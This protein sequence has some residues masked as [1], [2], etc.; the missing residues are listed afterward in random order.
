MNLSTI[1]KWFVEVN[2]EKRDFISLAEVIDLLKNIEN[3]ASCRVWIGKD[4]GPRPWWHRLLGTQKRFV[5]SLFA[6]E[7]HN[8]IA[9][10]IFHDKNWSEHRAIDEGNPV[11][12]KEQDRLKVAQGEKNA[13]SNEECINKQRALKAVYEYLQKNKR[14]DWLVYNFVE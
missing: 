3:L 1:D 7:W 12:A 13:P 11:S 8:E 5:V 6:L 14:P 2:N 10:L 9:N 4:G